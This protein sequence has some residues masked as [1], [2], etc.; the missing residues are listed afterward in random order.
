M[1]SANIVNFRD[2]QQP[3]DK[4][5]TF[6]LDFLVN[7]RFPSSVD[8]RIC[9]HINVNTSCKNISRGKP[10]ESKKY[11]KDTFDFNIT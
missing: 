7:Y 1:P 3:L 9:L 6:G 2:K 4:K 8:G 5:E 11:Y 10:E